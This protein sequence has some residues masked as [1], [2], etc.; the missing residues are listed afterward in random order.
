MVAR[1]PACLLT[2]A[3]AA[4]TT[5]PAGGPLAHSPWLG[6]KFE[7]ADGEAR[8]L[9]VDELTT[10]VALARAPFTVVLP[11][12]GE[13]DTYRITAWTDDT[14]H[15]EAAPDSRRFRGRDNGVPFYFGEATGMADTAAGSGTL[16]LND[17]GHHFLNGLRLGPE[18]DRHTFH[19]ASML[20]LGNNERREYPVS[21]QSDPLYLVAWFD[22]DADG[23]MDHS[24]YEFLILDF[25]RPAPQAAN[26]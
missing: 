7:Q 21:Q 5:V 26:R 10:Q 18:R 4:C 8:L 17:E 14:V 20:Y 1:L 25:N 22:E 23:S 2:L 16:F 11:V 15:A 19:V 3:A 6:L 24:E 13:D 9:R 12:R